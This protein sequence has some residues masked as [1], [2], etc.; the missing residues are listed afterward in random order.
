MIDAGHLRR[1]DL[2]GLARIATDATIGVA[3]LVEALHGAIARPLGGVGASRTRGVTGLVYGAV[4]GVT[5]R[6][7]DCVDAAL[8]PPAPTPAGAASSR[9][10]EALLA[11]LNGVLGEHLAATG[12]P[13]AIPMSLQCGGMRDARALPT[14]P[15]ATGSRLLVLVHGLCMNPLQWNRGGHDHGAVLACALGATPVYLHYNT[16]LHTSTNGRAFAD[17]LESLVAHWPGRVDEVVLLAHSMGGLVARSAC[18]HAAAADHAWLRRLSA[19]VFVGTPHHGA[20]LERVGHGIER[21]LG[22]TRWSAPFARL[23]RIRSAGITDLRFGNVLDEHWQGRDRFNAPSNTRRN[24]PLPRGVRCF[25]VAASTAE[26]PQP[27]RDRIVGDGLV[28]IDSALGRHRDPARCLA[29]PASHQW[30]GYGMN[31]LDLLGRADV[32]Q[33]IARWLKA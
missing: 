8:R 33:R 15:R 2:Q 23:G 12:N 22:T 1:S 31:H 9:E 16:G 27:L 32:A 3:D 7:G 29:F 4:R 30:I 11:A 14:V 5:R 18:N 28:T 10:R 19:L 25:A 20:P 6:V 13:L 24:L 21:L 26:G 17:Q